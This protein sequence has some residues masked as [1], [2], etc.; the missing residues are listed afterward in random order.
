MSAMIACA[1][2]IRPPAPTP[3]SARKPT[4]SPIDRLSPASIEPARKITIAARNTG[5]RPY[6]SPSLPYSG[7][8]AVDASRYEVTTHERCSRPPRSRTIVGSAVDTIV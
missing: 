7:V 5:L 3:C 6:M 2:T 4:S 8:E 1:P